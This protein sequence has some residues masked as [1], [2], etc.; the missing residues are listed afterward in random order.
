MF[1]SLELLQL[2]ITDF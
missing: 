1:C 2:G